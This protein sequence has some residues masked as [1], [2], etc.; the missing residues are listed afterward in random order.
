MAVEAQSMNTNPLKTGVLTEHSGGIGP[1]T[2]KMVRMRAAELAVID[3]RSAHETSKSDWEQAKLELTGDANADSNE[4][5]LESAPESGRWDVVHGS[6]GT[7]ASVTAG[8]DEDAE[9]RRDRKS[10]V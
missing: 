4:S 3:G 7:Q 1:A 8:E 10:V 5:L 2:R 6:T 9:G